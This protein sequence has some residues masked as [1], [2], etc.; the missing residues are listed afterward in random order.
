MLG[1]LMIYK[2]EFPNIALCLNRFRFVYNKL[3]LSYETG[4]IDRFDRYVTLPFQSTHFSEILSFAFE[5]LASP[6]DDVQTICMIDC[7]MFFNLHNH[8]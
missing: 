1:C 2:T 6:P 5:T 4:N 7:I 3:C 8:T